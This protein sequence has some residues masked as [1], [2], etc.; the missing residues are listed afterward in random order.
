MTRTILVADDSPAIQNKA[1]GILTGEGFDV[2]T[3]SNGV[4]A[5]KK[6]AQVN[7]LVILADVSMPGKDGYEVCDF[8]KN[9]P[10]LRHV[11]VLL[12][13]SD[14]EDYNRERAAQ[15]RADGFISKRAAITPFDA[16]ELIST[17]SRFAAQS[18]STPA[19]NRF[20]ARAAT[21]AATVAGPASEFTS[22]EPPSAPAKRPFDLASLHGDV[23]FTEPAAEATPA[24]WPG[25]AHPEGAEPPKGFSSFAESPSAESLGTAPASHIQEPRPASE[26][27]LIDEHERAGSETTPSAKLTPAPERTL[28]FSTPAEVAGPV[29]TDDVNPA[30]PWADS[31]VVGSSVEPPPAALQEPEQVNSTPEPASAPVTSRGPEVGRVPTTSLESFSLTEAAAG[32]VQFR[33]TDAEPTGAVE[34]PAAT[35][36]EASLGADSANQSEAQPVEAASEPAIELTEVPSPAVEGTAGAA[37]EPQPLD[38]NLVTRV[39]Q[40]VVTKMSPAAI[41]LPAIEEMV[42]NLVGEVVTELNGERPQE[43]PAF[44][45]TAESGGADYS[46]GEPA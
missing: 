35:P 5:I 14:M 8:V 34:H 15:V 4:A 32:Q 27:V 26:P 29:L 13:V 20:P 18:E 43:S 16:Q 6:L 28:P 46:S 17:V 30:P 44:A 36:T 42:N 24:I 40:K 12:V 10:E 21:P 9:S 11:A 19:L 7:P 33:A 45:E 25:S 39:V 1:K 3:V 37:P 38:V 23:A 22:E 2:I 41:P 31:P